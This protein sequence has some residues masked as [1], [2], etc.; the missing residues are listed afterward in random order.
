MKALIWI[1]SLFFLVLIIA[2]GDMAVNAVLP[3]FGMGYLIDLALAGFFIFTFPKW[4]CAKW[5]VKAF[6][7]KARKRGMKP[8][9]YASV[10]FP[11]SL[12]D[13][14]EVYQ[15]DEPAFEELMDKNIN[16]E[17]ITKADANVLRHM[18]IR[19]RK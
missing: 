19:R 17:A 6:E 13:A 12:L 15:N 8:G 9:E 11:S 2:I 14:C 4:L 18:F 7:K 3:G 16:G 1:G 10:T 5:D